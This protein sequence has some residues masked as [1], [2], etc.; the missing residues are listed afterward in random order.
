MTFWGFLILLLT[1]IETYGD[2]FQ[3][4][5][6]IPF[7]GQTAVVGFL[8]DTSTVVVFFTIAVF[9]VIRLVDN[10]TKKERKSVVSLVRT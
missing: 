4:T 8:E 5:F 10:P 2:L 6:H 1:I 9:A 3:K 7:I